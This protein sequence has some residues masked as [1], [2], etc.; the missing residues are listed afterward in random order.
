MVVV[1]AAALVAVAVTKLSV[2]VEPRHTCNSSHDN[3]TNW[4]TQGTT[5]KHKNKYGNNRS[6]IVE[7]KTKKWHDIDCCSSR[8]HHVHRHKDPRLVVVGHGMGNQVYGRPTPKLLGKQD[9]AIPR[10]KHCFCFSS[11]SHELI[12]DKSFWWNLL[13]CWLV[14]FFGHVT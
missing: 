3:T 1:A 9:L 5:S 8:S 4:N 7:F 12:Y 2:L 14:L 6:T 13:P 11:S 10:D